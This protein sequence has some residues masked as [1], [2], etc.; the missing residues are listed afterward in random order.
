MTQCP[1]CGHPA[2]EANRE[3]SSCGI[4]FG[5]WQEREENIA[6]GNLGRYSALAAATSSEFNWTILSIVFFLVLG[7]LYYFRQLAKQ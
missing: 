1:K 7:I 4:L 5:K 2:D 3:C 6:S